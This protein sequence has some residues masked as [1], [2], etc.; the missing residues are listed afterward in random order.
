MHNTL[1]VFRKN[2]NADCGVLVLVPKANTV[3]EEEENFQAVFVLHCY[4]KLL[5]LYTIS[6]TVFVLFGINIL[7]STYYNFKTVL[8]F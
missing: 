4:S 8:G 6:M 5:N 7:N 2:Q 3:I 1:T